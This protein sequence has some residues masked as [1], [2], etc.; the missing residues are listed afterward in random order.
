MAKDTRTNSKATDEARNLLKEELQQIREALAELKEVRKDLQ[1][2]R[3]LKEEIQ[4][5]LRENRELKAQNERLERRLQEV[6]QYQRANNIE[7]K[8]IPLDGEPISLVKQ[9]GEL[10]TEEINEADIDICHRVPT[11]KHN[12]TNIIVRF[13][14]RIKRNAFLTKARK[15]KLDTRMLGFDESCPVYINEHLTRQGKQ[16]L[17]AAIQ[18]KRDVQWKFVWTSGGKVF[19]RRNETSPVLRIFSTEDLE[20]MTI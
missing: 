18:K 3:A 6:E 10:V 2:F 9:I 13:V 12:E 19:A 16:L 14:R 15:A 17:G 8:G 1:D 20:K 11:A 4:E 5:V 7:I